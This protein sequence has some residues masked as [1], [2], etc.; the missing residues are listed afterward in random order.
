MKCLFFRTESI[1]MGLP[2]TSKAAVG[3]FVQVLHLRRLLPA[4]AGNF[5]CGTV[6]LGS[7]H[8][9]LHAP[10][11][12]GSNLVWQGLSSLWWRRKMRQNLRI[13][14]WKFEINPFDKKT[15]KGWPKSFEMF[16]TFFVAEFLKIAVNFIIVGN[17]HKS[18][19]WTCFSPQIFTRSATKTVSFIRF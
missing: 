9:N 2:I 8:V 17:F 16:L 11:L 14:S 6:Y 12:Q 19:M 5:T 1:L 4:A 3:Y 18:S 10:V 13:C 15:N 7:S